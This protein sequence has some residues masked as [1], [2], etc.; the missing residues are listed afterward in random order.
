MILPTISHLL[1]IVIHVLINNFIYLANT[2]LYPLIFKIFIF[3]YLQ[4]LFLSFPQC[5]SLSSA[6]LRFP[7]TRT[8]ASIKHA[9]PYQLA[10]SIFFI[11]H[12]SHCSI[13][14]LSSLKSPI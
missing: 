7:E 1:R 14:A 10:N 8:C 5:L 3:K 4:F 9:L 12:N 11:S 6:E 13:H 2:E